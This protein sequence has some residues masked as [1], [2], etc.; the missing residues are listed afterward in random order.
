M[1]TRC[2]QPLGSRIDKHYG[3]LAPSALAESI[4]TLAPRMGILDH[5]N[6]ASLE[7]MKGQSA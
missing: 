5:E 1:R 4:R 7:I 2:R 3:H 6:V